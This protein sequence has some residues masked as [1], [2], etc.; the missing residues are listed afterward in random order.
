MTQNEAIMYWS[1]WQSVFNM[2]YPFDCRCKSAFQC[3][4]ANLRLYGQTLSTSH[5]KLQRI[6]KVGQSHYKSVNTELLFHI[7]KLVFVLWY[8]FHDTAVLDQI[9]HVRE[10]SPQYGSCCFW[11]EALEQAAQGGRWWSYLPSLKA[12]KKRVDVASSDVG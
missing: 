8:I 11:I 7:N 3:Q 9:K 6:V 5:E 2:C 1:C 10:L 4:V 12:F